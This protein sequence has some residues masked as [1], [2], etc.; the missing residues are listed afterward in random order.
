MCSWAGVHQEGFLQV[1]L[2]GIAMQRAADQ[3]KAHDGISSSIYVTPYPEINRT[4]YARTGKTGHCVRSA[5]LN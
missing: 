1:S 4:T 5:F 3:K 2:A